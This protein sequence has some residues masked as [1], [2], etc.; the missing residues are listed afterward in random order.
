MAVVLVK[1]SILPY[2]RKEDWSSQIISF[3]FSYFCPAHPIL[4]I[5]ITHQFHMNQDIY[6]YMNQEI[7]ESTEQHY[8]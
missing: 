3:L 7:H 1:R 5:Q 8:W 2:R 4:I 6:T